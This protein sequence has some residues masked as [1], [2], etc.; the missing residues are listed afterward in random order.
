MIL[1]LKS[2]QGGDSRDQRLTG[3]GATILAAIRLGTSVPR[4]LRPL[5]IAK[6]E[7]VRA[8]LWLSSARC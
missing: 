3:R 5:S 1:I 8:G 6:P 2:F 7:K 4:G